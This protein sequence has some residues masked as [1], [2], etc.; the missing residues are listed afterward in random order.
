MLFICLVLFFSFI[1]YYYYHNFVWIQSSKLF[2]A[3]F[4]LQPPLVCPSFF[5]LLLFLIRVRSV[6]FPSLFLQKSCSSSSFYYRFD[7]LY[8]FC[9]VLSPLLTPLYLLRWMLFCS[10]FGSLILMASTALEHF[11]FR[12]RLARVDV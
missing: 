12:L 3:I 2:S 5:I 6:W 7:F 9:C 10:S 4:L 11:L 1:N 8:F